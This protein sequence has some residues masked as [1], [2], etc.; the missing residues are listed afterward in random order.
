MVRERLSGLA[1]NRLPARAY[2][3][4]EPPLAEGD[5]MKTC[6]KCNNPQPISNFQVDKTAKD[7]HRS[8][9]KTCSYKVSIDW[10]RSKKGVAI[11]MWHKHNAR[12]ET[13]GHDKPNYDRE[14]LINFIMNHPDYERLHSE[15]VASDFCKY[16]APSIDRIDDNIG[17]RKDNIRLVSFQENVEHAWEAGRKREYFNKGWSNGAC[18]DHRPVVQLSMSGEYISEFISVSEASRQTGSLD[19]KISHSCSGKRKSHNGS[20][21]VYADEY[22]PGKKYPD[23]TARKYTGVK[24]KVAKIDQNGQIISV[25]ESVNA[26]SADHGVTNGAIQYAASK[27]GNSCGYKWKYV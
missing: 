8:S 12:S 9:C 14:W 25:Y 4:K 6:S 26:A 18:G 3:L 17:Y 22:N 19:S 2:P 20:Q 13:R 11:R 15:Y 7:G 24:R 1:W 10:N 21:W 27:G 5:Q 23:L 16:K